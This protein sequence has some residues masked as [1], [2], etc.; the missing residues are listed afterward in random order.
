MKSFLFSSSSQI[1][2]QAV[3]I[4]VISSRGRFSIQIPLLLQ[5]SSL[6]YP[7]IFNP[8]FHPQTCNSRYAGPSF[9][10]SDQS[11]VALTW[12]SSKRTCLLLLLP[13]ISFALVLPRQSS[14]ATCG[15]DVYSNRAISSAQ[16]SGCSHLDS[17]TTVGSGD[18]PHEYH[19][20]EG[21]DFP[22]SGPWYEYPILESG[23]VFDGSTSPGADRVVFND[24][25]DLAGVITHTGASEQDGFV[26]C[27][28]A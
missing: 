10:F 6:T 5:N 3:T 21:F 14:G 7:L 12:P 1:N 2:S 17:G 13:T 15:S 18:Y 9:S 8:L 25:C 20:Y 26:E 27:R 19:D 16:S 22:V 24:D 23:K 28:Y 11:T 4:F